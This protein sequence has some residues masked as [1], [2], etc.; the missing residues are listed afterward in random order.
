MKNSTRLVGV[1]SI[2]VTG[3]LLLA[4]LSA[5]AFWD[6]FPFAKQSSVSSSSG[7]QAGPVT[8]CPKTIKAAGVS[9]TVFIPNKKGCDTPPPPPPV[10]VCPNVP[11]NQSSGPCADQVCEDQGGTWDGNSCEFPPLPED[12]TLDLSANPT[13]IVQGATSTL[14]W[15]SNHTDSCVASG[16]WN[17][18]K[19]LDGTQLVSPTATTTY[20][21]NCVGEGGTTTDSVTVNVTIPP[22]PPVD[23]CPNVPGNQA[24]GPCADVECVEDG[25]TWD[26]D[27]CNLP[28]PPEG[29]LLITE[30][31]YDLTNSTTTPQGAEPGNEWVEL[32]NGTNAD[33]NLSG[34]F[35]ADASSTD[36][37]P[38]VVLPAGEYAVITSSSTTATFWDIPNGAVVVVL[39]STIGQNGLTNTGD[40]VFLRNAASTTVDAVSWG[41]NTTAFSPSVPTVSVNSGQSI[42]RED[43]TVDTNTAGD[44]ES[45]VTPT[46]G[47]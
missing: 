12:P 1:V 44:W 37:L 7:I 14:N 13:S 20:T 35:I 34:Y 28:P 17:G 22:S 27:S 8:L 32:F 19:S 25:G 40:A 16:G 10:D 29:N 5:G 23:V 39:S 4:P 41:T 33:I 43:D 18:S 15:D 46:P 2:L 30:V 31:L 36:A 3:V 26:G 11:G 21:L 38:N 9:V 6:G 45:R 47:E 42:A 24:A